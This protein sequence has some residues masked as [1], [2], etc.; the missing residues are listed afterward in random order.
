[1]SSFQQT[2]DGTSKDRVQRRLE[3]DRQKL[4]DSG[5]Y[6]G[7][8]NNPFLED[9]TWERIGRGYHLVTKESIEA[10]KSNTANV[11][12]TNNQTEDETEQWQDVTIESSMEEAILSVVVQVSHDDCWLTPCGHW[13]GPN[14]VTKNFEDLKLSF[15]GEQ[16][17]HEVFSQDF[18]TVVKNIRQLFK[19]QIAVAG[20][21]PN[22]VQRGFLSTSRAN[23][24][25]RLK[26]RHVL[27]EKLDENESDTASESEDSW[28]LADWP[29]ISSEAEDAKQQMLTTHRVVPLPAYDIKGNLIEPK[30]YQEALAGALVRVNFTMAHWYIASNNESTNSFVANIKSVRVLIDPVVAKSPK[31]RKTA[32][33]ETEIASPARRRRTD[34]DRL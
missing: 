19:Q 6:L 7:E 4:L 31:K 15:H 16:P 2:L 10:V 18:A 1:M 3:A 28:S 9:V 21:D 8:S 5:T 29:V 32:K 26:F 24:A 22:A 14:Q 11:D 27:F 20:S 33:Q 23:N 25:E 34:R 13:K 17:G 30:K 12:A